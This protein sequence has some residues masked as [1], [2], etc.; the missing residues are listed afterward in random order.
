MT[1]HIKRW[2]GTGAHRRFVLLLAAALWLGSGVALAAGAISQGFSTTESD[3]VAG[4]VVDLKSGAQNAAELASSDRNDQ[5]LGI[6][7]NESL[8][9]LGGG[10]KQVQVVTSG[11]TAALVSDINGDIKTGDKI[12]A[13]PIGGIGM[14]ATQSTTVVGT[15]QADLD[16]TGSS[17]RTIIDKSGE[18]ITIHIGSIPVQVNVTYYVASQDKLSPLVP[19]FMQA[20]S[21]SIAGHNVP[22]LRVLGSFM[23]LIL[24]FLTATVMLYS[25]VR[26]GLIS[27]GRNPMAQSA[28]RKGLLQVVITAFGILLLTLLVIYILLAA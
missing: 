2:T 26:S 3:V 28:L 27:I 10:A 18:S 21:N 12:T 22:A 11:L 16:S 15:A 13:S 9:E 8:I 1:S 24:G 20:L 5:L 14:K 19:S 6:V 25:A 4:S 23:A 7:G 17:S